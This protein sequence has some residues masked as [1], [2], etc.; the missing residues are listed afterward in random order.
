MFRGSG[1]AIEFHQQAVWTQS[2]YRF[3]ILANQVFMTIRFSYYDKPPAA[4]HRSFFGIKDLVFRVVYVMDW[5]GGVEVPEL[6]FLLWVLGDISVGIHECWL[7][8]L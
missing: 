2:S 6:G 4:Y 3:L 1:K 8:E 7:S 5:P